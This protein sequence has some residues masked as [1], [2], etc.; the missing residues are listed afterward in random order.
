MIDVI[1]VFD[2]GKTNKKFLLFNENLEVVFHKEITFEE[3][4]DDD[5]FACDDILRIEEWMFDTID[6][7][8]EYYNVK[9]LNFSTYGASLVY[10]DHSGKR[11]APLYN[12]LKPLN[13]DVL[14]GFFEKY[15]GKNEFCRK[16][17][18]PASGML[19]SGFQILWMKKAKP[20]VFGKVKSILH[21]PQ[22]LSYLFTRKITADLT[23][24][25]CHTGLWDFDIMKYHEWLNDKNIVLPVPES[26]DLTF[27]GNITNK[28]VNVGIGIHDSSA[29]LV[30]YLLFSPQKFILMS[31]G[32]WC[33]IMNP[34][35]NELLTDYQL[36][37]DALC[38]LSVQQ[39]P[40]KSSRIFLGYIHQVN[41]KRIADFFGLTPDFYE[42]V[43]T[44]DNILKALIQ[45]EKV[46]FKNGM[47]ND[48]VDNAVDLKEYPTA[49]A[50]YQQFVVDLTRLAIESLKLVI[51]ENDETKII[52]ISGGFAR[53]EIFNRLISTLVPGKK[54]Y[55]TSVNN[56]S[57]LGAA[58][59]VWNKA[60][61]S[62]PVTDLGLKEIHPI[63]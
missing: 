25:G 59:S 60:F 50:A 37:N 19:N 57:A 15:G 5:G 2:I 20:V 30:P 14:D 62:A 48:F 35:N 46:F 4:K 21:F 44:D 6:E 28:E 31:T 9:A 36:S 16:T 42:F 38:Y 34:F 49:A 63:Y 45:N 29:S 51:P 7:I 23:S 55:T 12:Y 58:L 26:N 32:T 18:S 40:V 24:I 33:V 43:K 47:T 22:Y 1:A 10:L 52:Y 13:E 56:S 3:I 39:K 41:V 54:V 61:Q 53:S 8:E 17:A 11:L 27:K